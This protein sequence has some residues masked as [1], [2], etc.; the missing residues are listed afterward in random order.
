MPTTTFIGRGPSEDGEKPD[1]ALKH[2]EM[3][4]EYDRQHIIA[5]LGP[6]DAAEILCNGQWLI[7]P[8]VI[9]CL[10]TVGS[11]PCTSYFRA[12]TKFRWVADN[13]NELPTAPNRSV[14]DLNIVPSDV[15][16]GNL[17]GRS[18]YLFARQRTSTK[19]RFLG[20][21]GPSYMQ[22]GASAKNH[23]EAEFDLSPALPS[24]LWAKIGGFDA[25]DTSHAAVDAALSRLGDTAT[26]EDRF[27]VLKRLVEYW[28][29]PIL[30]D[31]GIPESDLAGLPMPSVLRWWYRWAGKRTE[32]M[33]GQNILFWP[34][35]DLHKYWQLKVEDDFLHFYIENQGVYQWATL[36]DGDEPPVFG[37]W[38]CKGPWEQ[39]GIT[40]SEHLILACIF[41]AVNCHARYGASKGWLPPERYNKLASLIPPLRIG[42]WRWAGNTRAYAKNGV[43]MCA[44]GSEEDGG[45]SVCIGAKTEHPLQVVKP[46]LDNSWEYVAT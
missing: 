45:Y 28:H 6:T 19:Y 15:I 3:Y 35:N 43:F 16:G 39:E 27:D 12:A 9:L 11:T 5:P 30:P 4:H 7:Y 31:D 26:V 10:T 18:I 8:T 17:K 29:G 24:E 41:E 34:R 25:G 40:V 1:T 32:I 44:S 13:T 46:M 14:H 38:E 36:P 21:L 2:V 20:K 42:S 23:G 22:Q 33:T 37:R